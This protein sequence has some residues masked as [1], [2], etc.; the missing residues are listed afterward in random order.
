[1]KESGFKAGGLRLAKQLAPRG[2]RGRQQVFRASPARDGWRRALQGSI[3]GRLCK[4]VAAR[5]RLS[6]EV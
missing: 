1:L 5:V 2:V 3:H 4:L 6:Y